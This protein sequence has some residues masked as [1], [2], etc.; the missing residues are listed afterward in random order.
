MKKY[1][2][3]AV[4][5]AHAGA[6]EI[7]LRPILDLKKKED[8]ILFKKITDDVAQL[9][10]KYNG[11][12][13]G[14]HGSGI[15]RASYIPM[16]VGQDNFQMMKEI[17]NVFD[18][19]QIFNPGKIF[20]PYPIDRNLRYETDRIEPE[21]ETLMDFSESMG[22]LRVAEKC[23]GSGDC[24][25]SVAAGGT[26]CP[27]YRATKDEKDATR[28][29]ANM[30]REFLTNSE[31]QNPFNHREL[32]QVFDLCISCK[33]CASECPSNVDVATL[34]AEFE[35]QY[36]KANGSSLRT[37]LFAHNN[38]ANKTGRVV[39]GITNFMFRNAL[40]SGVIKAMLGI[41]NQR[42]LPV[43]SKHSVRNWAKL[44]L[45]A[46]QPKSPLQTLYFFV[47][48]F[49]D[50]L[51]ASVGVDAIELLTS[52]GYG[53]E[54][55]KHEESGRSYISKGFLKE[56]KEI[57]NKNIE[58]FKDCISAETPLIGLEPSAILTFRDEYIRLAD[59]KK[60]ATT[61]A[62]HVFLID[63]F[64]S[65]E[66][67]A[68]RITASQFIGTE[69]T[70][71]LHGHCH[72]KALSKIQDTFNILNVP[73]NYKVTIIPSGCCGMAGSFGYE[74]EHYD[75]S[76]KIGEHTLFPAVRKAP[77]NTI[78]AATGT[79]CRHQIKDG[80]SRDAL[81]PISIL[82]GA[83]IQKNNL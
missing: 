82:R 27:S 18:P 14:E 74:K 7:H 40:T 61:L 69:K 45:N 60:Q 20:D 2:Q 30:L 32:K 33:G 62:K 31:Q 37:K 8:V 12:M 57:A 59:Q 25:K 44:N 34:K 39:I 78:I 77:E 19:Q 42:T 58:I 70:I 65:N 73:E 66:I 68:G 63:E 80:T 10:K 1:G 53:V 49:T 83:L 15:V 64:L 26:M 52:L 35:Y 4:Y 50:Q 21:I 55:I 67:T 75:I 79:S 11:S 72:Q 28:G 56:A 17:K 22:I 41:A 13:S 3:N 47:D 54:I 48:E 51:D 76:M 81:H 43:L 38:S 16:M 36:K 29:R 46:L 9:V 24:R 5:Y 71:K 23:N 6:G